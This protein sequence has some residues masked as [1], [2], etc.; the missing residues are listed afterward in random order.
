M[1]LIYF[2]LI[3][4][5]CTD[6]SGGHA[7]RNEAQKKNQQTGL[8]WGFVSNKDIVGGGDCLTNI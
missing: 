7:W 2:N 5:I 6:M 3:E 8:L 4:S 1:G